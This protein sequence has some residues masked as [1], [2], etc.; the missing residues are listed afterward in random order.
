M[1]K[2]LG[3]YNQFE[4]DII[5]EDFKSFNDSFWK[6]EAAGETR[7]QFF[8]GL[9]T[10]VIS[11]LVALATTVKKHTATGADPAA[12][13]TEQ[14]FLIITAVA[15]LSLIVIGL[16]TFLRMVKRNCVTDEYKAAMD[17]IRQS[18][19]RTGDEDYVPVTKIKTPGKPKIGGLSSFV[20]VINGILLAILFLIWASVDACGVWSTGNLSTRSVLKAVV[21]GVLG[22]AIQIIWSNAFR[23]EYETE[24]RKKMGFK[25]EPVAAHRSNPS[26]LSSNQNSMEQEATLII[27]GE[28]PDAIARQIA[29]LQKLAA[30]RLIQRDA[31]TI[32]DVYWDFP[33]ERLA[34][35]HV[36]LRLRYHDKKPLITLKGPSQNARFSGGQSRSEFEMPWS[37]SAFSEVLSRLQ[38]QGLMTSAASGFKRGI[39]PDPAFNDVGLKTV[40]VRR[41]LRLVR[42]VVKSTDS[43]SNVLA[44]LSIDTTTFECNDLDI[45]HHEIEIE[46]KARGGELAAEELVTALVQLFPQNLRSWKYSKLATGKALAHLVAVN[47]SDQ[48]LG[49]ANVLR[50]AAYDMIAAYLG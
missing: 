17:Y 28:Q 38:A 42:D 50:P 25:K 13:I 44:E 27:T 11:G 15:L 39:G 7:V 41:T 21:I 14:S 23:D 40:Q 6:N 26:Q 33:D 24:Y 5:L 8:I 4:K 29:D 16:I 43:M 3:D 45:V 19:M 48:L 36:A 49:D 47:T 18:Y 20:A 1:S 46:A 10:A 9:V 34:A 2:D 32:R 12:L 31:L 35:N 30:Y 37:D 22:A